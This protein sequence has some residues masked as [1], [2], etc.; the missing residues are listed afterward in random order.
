MQDDK[1]KQ[2][3]QLGQFVDTSSSQVKSLR[4]EVDRAQELF[5]ECCEYFG[6]SPKTTDTNAF[7][8]YFVRFL[9]T[10]KQSE[11]GLRLMKRRFRGRLFSLVRK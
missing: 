2:N 3:Q 4:Q 8:G 7:F 1:A 10:W 11:V 9:A 6:E 5:R